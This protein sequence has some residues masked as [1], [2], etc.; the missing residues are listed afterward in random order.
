[1]RQI[2]KKTICKNCL[3]NDGYNPDYECKCC[4]IDGLPIASNKRNRCWNGGFISIL[5]Y[6]KLK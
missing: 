3:N 2:G 4:R 6:Y 1:M 5:E